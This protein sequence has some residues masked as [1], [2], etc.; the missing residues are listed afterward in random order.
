MSGLHLLE[1]VVNGVLLGALYALFGLG[2]SLSLGVM[3]M[4]NIA[5]GD[6]IVLAAYLTLSTGMALGIGPPI[7]L[8]V[9]APGMFLLGWA[10]Q[11]GILNR[12]VG[13]DPLSVLL[14][15]FGLSIVLQN[16]LLELYSADTRSL[17][18]GELATASLSLGEFSTGWL[19]L[20]IAGV[21]LAIFSLTHLALARTSFGRQ[22]RAVASDPATAR[23]VGIRDRRLFAVMMGLI[24]AIVAI[25]GVFYGI[26]TPFS[27]SAGPERLLYAFEAVVLGGVGS[28][29]GTFVGGL[30]IGL[31]QVF[32]AQFHAGLGPLVGHLVFLVTLLARPNGLFRSR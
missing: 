32:G 18:A 30:V 28:V 21:S 12:L 23:L 4:I 3:R 19:P 22:A 24:F 31:S 20:V 16:L 29:W 5:H 10:L 11:R 9:T 7:A 25:G 14:V 6:L 2:L 8:L 26:R 15:T 17:A 27:P 1:V 13:R